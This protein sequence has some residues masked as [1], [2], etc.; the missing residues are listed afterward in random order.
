[1][2]A[3]RLLDLPRELRD[4][5]Y[6][7]ILAP[8]C[9]VGLRQEPNQTWSLW[10]VHP[11]RG[12]L[13][14]ITLPFLQASKQIH[15]KCAGLLYKYNAFEYG[16]DDEWLASDIGRDLMMCK[17]THRIQHLVIRI[18]LKP[19]V[20][21]LP[22][23]LDFFIAEIFDA[24]NILH[25][26]RELR[27]V[28]FQLGDTVELL[29]WLIH[30]YTKQQM[31]AVTDSTAYDGFD[32]FDDYL[33]QEVY[34][35][36]FPRR[37]EGL[38]EPMTGVNFLPGVQKKIVLDEKSWTYDGEHVYRPAPDWV[39]GRRGRDVDSLDSPGF[40]YRK[41]A[42]IWLGPCY[43]FR[44]RDGDGAEGKADERLLPLPEQFLEEIQRCLWGELWCE[45][46]LFRR[47]GE[48]F[49]SGSVLMDTW[50]QCGGH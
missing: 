1:M 4:I 25:R 23:F 40:F 29:A 45:G 12:F 39:Y 37:T 35:I 24:M 38:D 34:D 22:V 42:E 43:G 5:I 31:L 46:D 6:V 48:K 21:G 15:D 10:S 14:R 20:H 7:E 27:S 28:T 33:K 17:K 11:E 44:T 36:L 32:D 13:D 18:N 30:D 50:C 2:N 47:G 19:S 49:R 8:T 41:G 26:T 9:R 3:F 16:P